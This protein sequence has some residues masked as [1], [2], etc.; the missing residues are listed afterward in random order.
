MVC[1]YEK[2]EG[3]PRPLNTKKKAIHANSIPKIRYIVV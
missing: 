3:L 2:Q 1:Y